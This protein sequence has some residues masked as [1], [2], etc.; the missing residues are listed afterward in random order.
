[1]STATARL[2]VAGYPAKPTPAKEGVRM[3]DIAK[4]IWRPMLAMGVMVLGFAL[5]MGIISAVRADDFFSLSAATIQSATA[6]GGVMAD[7]AF[8]EAVS[9]G[10]LPPVLFLGIGFLLSGITFLLAT[11]LGTLRDGGRD[12]QRTVNGESVDLVKPITAK[13]FPPV[14]MMGLMVLM[15]AVVVGIVLSTLQGDYWAN[16]GGQVANG[17]ATAALASDLGSIKSVQA[18]LQPL[19]FVGMGLILTGI[20]LALATIVKALRF[21][22]GRV[23]QMYEEA[24]TRT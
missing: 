8:Y 6:G 19:N 23:I 5:V 2:K 22:A 10:W 9:N 11:I 14:M 4:K 15:A 16:A 7:R 17:P 1:M 24:E 13:L 20:I 12:V 18:W 3:S 21:Q